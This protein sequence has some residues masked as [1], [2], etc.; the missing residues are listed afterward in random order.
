LLSAAVLAEDAER[1][2]QC[3]TTTTLLGQQP[4]RST[5]Q[6]M[7]SIRHF[8]RA[9]HPFEFCG[10]LQYSAIRSS[11]TPSMLKHAALVGTQK[12]IELLALGG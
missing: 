11:P 1:F 2:E 8:N 5:E 7:G 12:G 3:L 4:Q 6:R 10:S 9:H